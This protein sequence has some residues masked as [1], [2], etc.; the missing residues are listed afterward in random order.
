MKVTRKYEFENKITEANVDNGKGVYPH[1]WILDSATSEANFNSF[2][3]F[4]GWFEPRHRLSRNK[5]NASPGDLT[6]T[7][8]NSYTLGVTRNSEK[9]IADT[10]DSSPQTYLFLPTKNLCIR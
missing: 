7:S 9:K 8:A 3:T 4:I 5:V 1:A 6:N 2:E 10:S